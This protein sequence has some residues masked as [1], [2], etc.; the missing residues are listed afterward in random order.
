MSGGLRR[1]GPKR[2]PK[3]QPGYFVAMDCEISIPYS[4]KHLQYKGPSYAMR[5][6][7]IYWNDEIKNYF[8]TTTTTE[9]KGFSDP[10]QYNEKTMVF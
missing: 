3:F 7:F 2:Q 9:D 4:V 5:I 1:A 6:P 8:D 10:D